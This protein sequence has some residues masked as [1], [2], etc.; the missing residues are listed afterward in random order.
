MT[1]VEPYDEGP[2]P[3]E[4]L[5]I[6]A[7]LAL[8]VVARC[9]ALLGPTP[10]DEELKRLRAELDELD[11]SGMAGARGAAGELALRAAAALSVVTGSR[12]LLLGD[13]AQ[14]LAREALFALV[15]ALRPDSCTALLAQLGVAR[16]GE[17]RSG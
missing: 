5:R 9:C 4:V 6:H 12:A 7:A 1:S 16:G 10:L 14:R 15:S 2:T 17:N 3:A 11:A 8:G 13:H